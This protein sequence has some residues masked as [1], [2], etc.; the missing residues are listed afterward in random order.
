MVI[1]ETSRLLLREFTSNDVGALAEILS[2]PAV[3]EFSTNGPC[4]EDDT[5]EFI[6]WCLE[7]YREHGFGQWGIVDSSSGAII[8]FCGL[9]QVDLNG[10]QE[11][12]IG[13]RLARIVWGQGLASEAVAAALAYGFSQCHIGSIVAIIAARHIAS[14]RVAEKVGLKIDT[15]TKYRDWNVRIYRKGCTLDTGTA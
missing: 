13:Y 4:T 5:R 9:S 8:G 3:M 7:S 15:Y 12:E 11:I 14:A 10:V 1:A 2:D 6:H